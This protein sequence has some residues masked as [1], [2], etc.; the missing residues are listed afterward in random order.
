MARKRISD[1]EIDRK[2][3]QQFALF[4]E[5]RKVFVECAT[6]GEV[7]IT[8]H[9][10]DASNEGL[11][12]RVLQL[13]HLMD[14]ELSVAYTSSPEGNGVEATAENMSQYQVAILQKFVES[15]GIIQ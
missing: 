4:A 1:E 15:N 12:D 10:C 7:Y 8:C 9:V 2:L 11:W 5:H 14:I 13:F 3:Q 6:N